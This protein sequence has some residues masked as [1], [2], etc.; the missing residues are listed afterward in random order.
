MKNVGA[1]AREYFLRCNRFLRRHRVPVVGVSTFLIVSLIIQQ[2]FFTNV[3]EVKAALTNARQE[4]NIT[5][6]YLTAASGASATSSAIVSIDPSKY[7]GATYYFEVVAST[8]AAV[9]A[10]IALVDSS[11]GVTARSITV[12]GTSYTRYR[13]TSFTVGA[14]TD[15]KVRLNT[16]AVRKGLIAARIVILQSTSAITTTQTQIEIGSVQTYTS[17]T[18]SGLSAPKYWKYTSANWDASPTFYAEVTYARTVDATVASSTTYTTSGSRSFTVPSNITGN[19]SVALRGGG[20]GGGAASTNSTGSGSGGAGGQYAVKSI[21]GLAGLTKTVVVGAFGAGGVSTV[22][23]SVGGNST[24][25]STV[26][27][28]N[29][30]NG[31]AVNSGAGGT[32]NT[33][34]AVGDTVNA[35]GNGAAGTSGG[36]SGGGGEGARSNGTGGSA[37]TGTGGTGGDGGDGANGITTNGTPAAGSNPGGGGAGGRSTGNPNADGGNGGVGSAVI[38]YN[39][40]PSATTTIKL[41]ESDGTGDGFAGWTDKITIV[42]GGSASTP[43]RIRSSSFTPTAGRNYRIAVQEGHNGATHAIYNAKIVVDQASSPTKLEAQYLLANKTLASGTGLQNYL[44]YWDTTE[45]TNTSNTYTHQ[46]DAA[47]GSASVI[48]VDTAAGAQVTGSVVSSPDNSGVSSS[49][50]M[51]A[52]G[53]NLD[54]KA[55]TNNGDVYASRILVAVTPDTTAPTPNPHTSQQYRLPLPPLRLA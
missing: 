44:T 12:N 27:V 21:S 45:W 47:N 41:Q 18:L 24:W 39:L 38:S 16:E 9:N 32:G 37:T 5:N 34:G 13:S 7:T 29:G 11:T 31:G 14:T 1:A 22:A 2:A 10:T 26:V 20:G 15:Y 23:G 55:T 46:V 33:T 3:P 6:V 25:D 8:S 40:N 51:P 4:V 17:G 42:S 53:N 28:A 19:V 50:T 49:M 36:I 43:T 54:V 35:G 48:E 30:G 52:T